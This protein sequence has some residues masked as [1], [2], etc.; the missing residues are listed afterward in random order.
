MK[1]KIKKLIS[2]V[3]CAVTVGLIL[4]SCSA[5]KKVP[6]LPENTI[7][8]TSD[9]KQLG[10]GKL[11]N[12]V[13]LSKG[14]YADIDFGSEVTFDTVALYEKGDNCNEFNIYIDRN[15]EWELVYK[16]D[17]ILKYHLCFIGEVTTSK[18]R[19]EIADCNKPVE[20]NELAVYLADKTDRQVKVSQYL[21]LDVNDFKDLKDDEGFS[22]YYDV[23][24][25]PILFGETYMDENANICFHHSEEFF[26]EQI[27]ALKEIIG[28]RDVRIWCC[29]FFDQN[30]E[31][32][33]RDYNL[34]KKFINENIDLITSNIK[35]FTEKYGIY[36]IDY[37]W[38]Y[39][40]TLSQWK[41]YDRIVEETAKVT[42]V[43]V[44][45]A[46]WGVK[47]SKSAVNA[48]ENVNIMAY[49]LFDDRGDHSNS[50]VAG[51]DAIRKVRAFGFKNEQLLLGIPTY[52][53]TTD[54]S[55][56]AWPTV[57]DDGRELGKWGKIV[58]DYA[59][60]DGNT[61]EEKTC[62]GYLNSYAEARD[63]TATAVD[64]GIG[65]VMIFRAFCDS[66]YTDEFSL[67]RGI[68]EAIDERTDY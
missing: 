40:N 53:R 42:K 60:T 36:G 31:D 34:T 22:G 24:T 49:D 2:A 67:H 7:P 28:D 51:Y 17:R 23:V 47:F 1:V 26:A 5:G 29:I 52:A 54:K 20:V 61:G 33:S 35:A 37:D 46:P 18:L 41:S 3:L 39:P 6:E 11:N 44:A 68:K 38:E 55:E 12:S 32:G 16:Q 57:R 63:K 27:N 50:Y 9:K 66:P 30:G 48:I 59:Y 14:E 65:G 10:D 25:D 8:Y 64:E 43:S 13:K 21:R 4:T 19:F 56:F 45:V 62:D 15:S 58:K